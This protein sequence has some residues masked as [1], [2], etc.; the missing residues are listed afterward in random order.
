MYVIAYINELPKTKLD[1]LTLSKLLRLTILCQIAV[2]YSVYIFS[3]VL[4]INARLKQATHAYIQVHVVTISRFRNVSVSTKIYLH[5]LKPNIIQRL[6]HAFYTCFY[7]V[8]IMTVL[9]KIH[10]AIFMY[11][12]RHINFS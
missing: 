8:L 12:P 10:S 1:N 5:L 6:R 9:K 11:Y 3:I 7:V 2:L 4:N